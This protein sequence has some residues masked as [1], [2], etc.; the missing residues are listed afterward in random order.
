M[1]YGAPYFLNAHGVPVIYL[2]GSKKHVNFGFLRSSDLAD[3]KGVLKGSG[4]PSKHI[5]VLPGEP[6]DKALL[7]EFMRQCEVMKP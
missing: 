7:T 4:T 1:R 5:K 3:P 2:F 6:Y